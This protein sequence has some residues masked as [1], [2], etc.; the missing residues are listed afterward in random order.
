MYGLALEGGGVKGAFH[1]GA[2]KAL[3]EEGYEFAGVAGT[4]IGALNGAIIAQ[5]DFEAGYSL[6]ESM[7]ASQLFDIEE[8]QYKKLIDRN[9]DRKLLIKLAARM[10]EIIENKGIDTGKM[11]HIMESIVNE[12]KLRKSDTDFGL[13]TVSITD[14]KPLELY[15]EDIPEGKLIDYLMA[16]ASFPGFKLKPIDDKYYID[17]GFYDNCPVNLLARKG[18]KEI[19]AVRTLSPGIV[20]HIKY[21]N[22]KV[23]NVIPSENL[24][25]PLDFNRGLIERNLQMGYY[26]TMR[27]L[28]GLKGRKYYVIPGK[29]DDS[30]NAFFGLP[31]ELVRELGKLLRYKT[32]PEKRMLFE[33]IIPELVDLLELED[34]SNYQDILIG[35]LEVLAEE[36]MVGRFNI[37]FMGELI[38]EI[39]ASI[40]NESGSYAKKPKKKRKISLN[41]RLVDVFKRKNVL[42]NAAQKIFDSIGGSD[43]Q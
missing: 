28:K 10:G 19:I 31:D 43:P 23:V 9:I 34:T 33:Y 1:M 37:Y 38:A 8:A 15:K 11:R 35:L 39:R 24:G 32:M 16:S 13:V 7:D 42:K 26:D 25:M 3:L 14:L 4:S 36:G 30:F 6:W 27:S 2:M 40:K 17:G 21:S 5:G 18:Y 29:E 12:E 20:Q 22:V 41:K